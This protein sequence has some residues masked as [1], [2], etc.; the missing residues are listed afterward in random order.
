[1]V[2][3]RKQLFLVLLSACGA[4]CRVETPHPVTITPNGP[5]LLY[6]EPAT[7]SA[8]TPFTIVGTG[9]VI[10]DMK[11]KVRF[12][13]WQTT[14]TA[15][16]EAVIHSFVPPK[17]T[18][19]DY[20]VKVSLDGHYSNALTFTVVKTPPGGG[21]DLGDGDGDGDG[22]NPP[23]PAPLCDTTNC[24]AGTQAGAGVCD[25]TGDT[26]TLTFSLR[27]VLYDDAL[28]NASV[29][30][31]D[32]VTG[33][34]TGVCGAT[35]AGGTI[36]LKAPRATPLAVKVTPAAPG[37]V[38]GY[39]FHQTWTTDATR[40]FYGVRAASKNMLTGAV[41]PF[42]PGT[43]WIFGIVYRNGNPPYFTWDTYV[44]SQSTAWSYGGATTVAAD[45]RSGA[46]VYTDS[47]G[48]FDD[49]RT[50]INPYTGRWVI[51]D[52]A[53][54]ALSIAYNED[55]V[56]KTVSYGDVRVYPGALTLAFPVCGGCP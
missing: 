33:I 5:G 8:D 14:P 48:Y 25:A 26:V 53:P 22:T 34:R 35:G 10:E 15:A 12:G 30:L 27:D 37:D 42:T 47:A 29:E 45:P 46:V 52:V 38:T 9:L 6:L 20:E 55:G 31:L 32:N 18:P 43:G 17:A 21:S 54:G 36:T 13:T 40:V 16:T 7:G 24:P 51:Y 3:L 2:H 49:T 41:A 19:G 23:P 50:S 44:F 11:P 28:A 56:R 39:T 1:M 4:A